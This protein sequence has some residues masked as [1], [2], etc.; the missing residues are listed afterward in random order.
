VRGSQS[1]PCRG[2]KV[3]RR[4]NKGVL[5]LGF[6]RDIYSLAG[7]GVWEGDDLIGR[8]KVA[9]LSTQIQALKM[10]NVMFV[11]TQATL[12]SFRSLKPQKLRVSRHVMCGVI[13]TYKVI[14]SYHRRKYLLVLL[15]DRQIT[16][17]HVSTK[18]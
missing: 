13:P 9:L 15:S 3:S 1:E 7:C 4:F 6:I 5:H 18:F 8:R 2:L 11:E 10:T 12:Y 14:L 16:G 17:H